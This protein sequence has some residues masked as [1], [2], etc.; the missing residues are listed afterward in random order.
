MNALGSYVSYLSGYIPTTVK[1][2]AGLIPQ[3]SQD[4]RHITWL[5]I[6]RV[7]WPPQDDVRFFLLLG[8]SDGFQIWDLQDPGVPREVLS[9]QDKP[10]AQGRLLPAPLAPTE[11]QSDGQAPALG[12]TAQPLMAYLHRGTPSL[13]RLFSLKEHDDVHLLRLTEPARS[14]QASRRYFAVG[15]A[16]QVELYD[17]LHFH[18]LFSVQCHGA[19]NPTFALGHRWLA[20][21]L[22]PQLP[23]SGNGGLLAGGPRQL[24]TMLKDGLQY[25]GQVGQ[26]TLDHVLMP[27]SEGE[28]QPPPITAARSGIVAVRDAVSRSVIAQFDDHNDAVEMMA[29]DPSGL[30]LVTCAALG[31]RVLVHR[32]MVGA[33]HALVMDDAADGG[34]TLGSVVFQHLYTLSRGVTPAVISD[35]SVSDDGRLVAVSSAKG[36]THVFCLPPLHGSCALSHHRTQESVQLAA[37]P[38]CGSGSAGDLGIGLSLGSRG[39]V[40]KPVSLAACTRVRLGSTL[41]QEGL[42]PQ[43]CFLSASHLGTGMQPRPGCGID[44]CPRMYVAT[45]AG[46]V[47]LYSLVP[48]AGSAGAGGAGGSGT[49]AAPC[50]GGG[51]AA[52]GGGSGSGPT[53][54]SGKEAAPIL[55]SPPSNSAVAGATVGAPSTAAGV[56][57]AYPGGGAGGGA[58]VMACGAGGAAPKSG[59]A[60]HR[61][62]TAAG[63]ASAAAGNSA[64]STESGDWQAVLCNELHVCRQLRHFKECRLTPRD[65]GLRSSRASSPLPSPRCRAASGSGGFVLS[66]DAVEGVGAWSRAASPA[67]GTGTPGRGSMT[68]KLR[69]QSPRVASSSPSPAQRF[70]GEC[71]G[72]ALAENS[73]W[74]AQV[75]TVTSVPSEVPLWLCPQLSFHAYPETLPHGELNRRLRAG[76]LVDGR[77]RIEVIR[78]ERPGEGVR[79]DGASLPGDERLSLLFGGALGAAVDDSS[80]SVA[81]FAGAPVPGAAAS[82]VWRPG[83][84]PFGDCG[85]LGTDAAGFGGGGRASSGP[86]VTVA[87]AWGSLAGD[88]NRTPGASGSLAQPDG[89]GD[90]LEDLEE[91]WLHA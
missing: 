33:Q 54:I 75:E 16:K 73:K 61:A 44:G 45:R 7:F 32:A 50:A 64:G 89:I 84:Q 67:S 1:D 8:Y 43:C 55:G 11:G 62:R 79:Y 53:A 37:A 63:G 90:G 80:G 26:R 2:A 19:A 5:S 18:S 34:L 87:P 40:R 21:N 17:A 29:W 57:G 12:I 35:V 58:G 68:P 25:L 28:G 59:S 15:L 49:H 74:L 81:V 42:L 85:V 76:Q 30:Q 72:G 82:G 31:H 9:R 23:L 78:P 13:V 88:G 60:A 48:G 10:F 51:A 41:L 47:A 24:P 39:R 52:G 56:D 27:P 86:S 77:R 6:E 46:G 91:D 20:Y 65:L 3:I 4:V 66:G 83:E 70:P 71:A 22:P 69:A 14:L 38:S 36:T